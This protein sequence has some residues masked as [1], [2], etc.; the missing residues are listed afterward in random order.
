MN[1]PR[2]FLT[3]R[4]LHPCTVLYLLERSHIYLV[5]TVLASDYRSL[6][7]FPETDLFCVC[8]MSFGEYK[9]NLKIRFSIINGKFT[10]LG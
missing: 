4:T 7:E 10:I 1:I 5:D 2:H 9:E 3:A 6:R 8:Q